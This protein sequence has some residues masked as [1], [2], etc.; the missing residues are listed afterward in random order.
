[1]AELELRKAVTIAN[2]LLTIGHPFAQAAINATAMDLV[3]W[4]HGYIADG[5]VITPE[6]QAEALVERARTEWDGWPEQGGTKQLLELFRSM[7][8]R[9]PEP[10]LQEEHRRLEREYGPPNKA[11]SDNL[12]KTA[13]AGDFKAEM[14]QLLIDSIESAIYYTEGNGSLEIEGNGKAQR[15]SQD[16]WGQ[17]MQHHEREH[18]QEVAEARQ[19]L[20]AN[21]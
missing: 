21:T 17:A 16:F 10:S 2:A 11:W 13:A 4:C 12:V 8:V 18:P 5:Q 7:Y 14:S 9:K 1:M 19:R 3:N 20:M 6:Q 15:E